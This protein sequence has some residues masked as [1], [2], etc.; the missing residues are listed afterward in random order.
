MPHP[1]RTPSGAACASPPR[2]AP[3]P[4]R[5]Q[6]RSRRPPRASSVTRASASATSRSSSARCSASRCARLV[7]ARSSAAS[8]LAARSFAAP[9]VPLFGGVVPPFAAP[10]VPR[11]FVP[12]FRRRSSSRSPCRLSWRPDACLSPRRLVRRFAAVSVAASPPMQSGL[13]VPLDDAR[14]AQLLRPVRVGRGGL[15]QLAHP[16]EH[17]LRQLAAVRPRIVADAG[18]QPPCR[19]AVLGHRGA[20]RVAARTIRVRRRVAQ[21]IHR[22]EPFADELGLL[23]R[24]VVERPCRRA[25]L[26]QLRE[27][28]RRTALAI[29]AQLL[30]EPLA[31][32]HEIL[33]RHRLQLPEGGLQIGHGCILARRVPSRA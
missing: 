22:G 8:C 23:A 10:F 33:E 5:R 17:R 12:P 20:Q 27:L 15:E 32:G 14:R 16:V 26:R 9:F 21:R 25:R 18:H 30:R 3:R 31:L 7:A 1:P 28:R 4:A 6:S 2:A 19:L 24:D 29:V 13:V 11:F